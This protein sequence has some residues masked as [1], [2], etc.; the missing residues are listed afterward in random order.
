MTFTLISTDSFG[1]F[2]GDVLRCVAPAASQL[3]HLQF[4]RMWVHGSGDCHVQMGIAGLLPAWS[5]VPEGS[6]LFVAL[7]WDFFGASDV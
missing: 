2:W 3:L 4:E 7:W 1:E 6:H 5:P